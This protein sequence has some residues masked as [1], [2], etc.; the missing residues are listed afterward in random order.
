MQ[1]DRVVLARRQL[2]QFGVRYPG[3]ERLQRPRRARCGP[4]CG[5]APGWACGRCRAHR[6]RR[7]RTTACHIMRAIIG[8]AHARCS[9]PNISR[10]PGT[11]AIGPKNKSAK[12][13]SPQWFSMS[14]RPA[15]ICSG[16]NPHGRS[17]NSW[18]NRAVVPTSTR[19][20]TRSGYVA[21]NTMLIGPP[22]ETPNSAG[23]STSAASSTARRSSMR[24]SIGG[25]WDTGSDSPVPRLSQTI[26]RDMSAE[27]VRRCRRTRSWGRR[28]DRHC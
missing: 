22:S 20:R 13:P 19:E 10:T 28:R 2:P 17:G 23:Y 1:V 21:A 4:P 12:A 6:G 3:G 14:S 9:L 8:L 27:S 16:V 18:E 15:A 26:S 7:S 24:S 5:P 25:T 11:S